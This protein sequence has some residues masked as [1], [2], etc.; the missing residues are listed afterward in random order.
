VG[1]GYPPPEFGKVFKTG[2]LMV[3]YR[4]KYSID[5]GLAVK[6]SLDRS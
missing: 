1:V 3:L 6:Y 5:G 4:A 2:W